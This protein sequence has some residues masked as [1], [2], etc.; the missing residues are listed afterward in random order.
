MLEAEYS[1]TFTGDG[2]IQDEE[3]PKSL[4]P[5]PTDHTAWA[6]RSYGVAF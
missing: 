4:A 3:G 2:E 5:P 6:A 1:L